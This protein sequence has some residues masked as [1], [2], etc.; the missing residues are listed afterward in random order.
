MRKL[1][2]TAVIAGLSSALLFAGSLTLEVANP[3]TNPEA[4]AKNAALVAR[5]TAC[6]SPEKTVVTAT[7]EST[8]GGTR[9]SIPLK[10]TNLSTPGTFAV[11]HEWPKDGAWAVV[12]IA[13]NPDYKDYAT[14]V[15]VPVQNDTF[16]WAAV[17][18]VYHRPT[19]GDIDAALSQN[20]L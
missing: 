18:H 4:V 8:S 2:G 17:K 7:A 14:S 1:L 11:S 13:T 20:S 15:L 6:N 9:R 16:S 5:I 3:K 10:V 12:M 19:V